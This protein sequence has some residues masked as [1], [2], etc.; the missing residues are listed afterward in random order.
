MAMALFKDIQ[1]YLSGKPISSVYG[2][3]YYEAYIRL[4][5]Q[6]SSEATNKW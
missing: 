6:L 3:A 5:T 4:L 2:L 1:L